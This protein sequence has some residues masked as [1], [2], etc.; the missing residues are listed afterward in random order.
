MHSA[1]QTSESLDF[2]R[3]WLRN[4]LQVGAVLP[5]SDALAGVMTRELAPD[6]GPILE[7][8]PGT[9]VFTRALLARGIAEASLTLVE[10]EAEFVPLLGARFPQARI[11]RMDAADLCDSD[12]FEGA[13][14]AAVI[15]GLPLLSMPDDKVTAILKGAF[16]HLREDGVFYQFTYA[17]KCPIRRRI[18]DRLGLKAVASGWTMRNCPPA[19]VY[20]IKRQ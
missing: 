15:S 10:Y 20:R 13:P 16:T 7:L 3:R 17:F 4:P 8:G 1:T 14:V 6:A 11:V 9:G 5:S 18:L 12:L 19:K 2:F